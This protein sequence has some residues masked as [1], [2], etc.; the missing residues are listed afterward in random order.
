LIQQKD[1][2]TS[3]DSDLTSGDNDLTSGDSISDSTDGDIDRST[4]SKSKSKTKSSTLCEKLT[5]ASNDSS[6][7]S[8]NDEDEEMSASAPSVV[9]SFKKMSISNSRVA[10]AKYFCK[11]D[12][13]HFNKQ[14]KIYNITD[15]NDFVYMVKVSP[16]V[17]IIKILILKFI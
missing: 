6:N 15:E 16:G 12:K 9:E 13:V 10:R 17:S 11:Y 2:L 5:E 7:N 1:N 4:P 8:S 14:L 3:G